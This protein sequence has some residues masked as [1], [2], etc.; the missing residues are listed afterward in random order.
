[1]F[2]FRKNR[3]EELKTLILYASKTGNAKKIAKLTHEYFFK[4]GSNIGCKNVKSYSP[5]KLI[6]VNNLLIVISTHGVGDPPPSAK[7]FF[8]ELLSEQMP[9][10]PNLNYTVCALGDSNYRLFCEAGRHIDNRLTELQ[11]KPIYPRTECDIDFS[12]TA[13]EWIKGVYSQLERTN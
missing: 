9:F 1:M 5:Q 8:A 7:S 4:N 10:L 3:K 13:I 12:T 6:N 2:Y 11:A